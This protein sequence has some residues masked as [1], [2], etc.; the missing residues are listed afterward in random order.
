MVLDEV[1]K[2]HLSFGSSAAVVSV[3]E[4]KKE[5]NILNF[6]CLFC[7]VKYSF[8]FHNSSQFFKIYQNNFIFIYKNVYKI[9]FRCAYHSCF[10]LNCFIDFEEDCLYNNNN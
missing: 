8:V 6:E 5:M 4:E 3:K 7:C 9:I 10:F 2:S 1:L